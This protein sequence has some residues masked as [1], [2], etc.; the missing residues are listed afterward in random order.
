MTV[1]R[2]KI[3]FLQQLKG[4][5]GGKKDFINQILD[6]A[7]HDLHRNLKTP[8]LWLNKMKVDLKLP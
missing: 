7:S 3:P 6:K 2:R 4:L 1:R 5:Q 8:E